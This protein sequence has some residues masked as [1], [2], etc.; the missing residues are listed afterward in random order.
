MGA[1]GNQGVA[2]TQEMYRDSQR[3]YVGWVL[4]RDSERT[5]LGNAGVSADFAL[6]AFAPAVRHASSPCD[7]A[8]AYCHGHQAS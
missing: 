3:D 8:L 7:Q 2:G 1:Y 6:P 4:T 5:V